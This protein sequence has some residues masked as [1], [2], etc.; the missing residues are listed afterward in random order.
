MNSV[1]DSVSIYHEGDVIARV[2]LV[3]NNVFNVE[4]KNDIYSLL[5]WEQFAILVSNAM[6]QLSNVEGEKE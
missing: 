3:D 6:N 1:I 5:E 2:S 4:M